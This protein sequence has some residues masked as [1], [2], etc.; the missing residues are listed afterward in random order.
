MA[1]SRDEYHAKLASAMTERALQDG[2]ATIVRDI[3]RMT[4]GAL[5]YYHTHR[6][7]HSP[8]GFPDVV[9]LS[10]IH[11]TRLVAELKR[12]RKSAKPTDPQIEWLDAF[13]ICGD[14]VYLWRPRHLL[15]GEIERLIRCV[16][17]G[18]SLYMIVTESE[19]RGES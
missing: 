1:I 16:A 13:Q 7:Q 14:P 18:M 15:S 4:P 12:E 2:V 3:N 6:S 19:W 11:G 8:A 17:D 9:I 5:L 10:L